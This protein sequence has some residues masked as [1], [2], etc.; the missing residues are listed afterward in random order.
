MP[1]QAV[2]TASATL[3]DMPL[4]SDGLG[5]VTPLATVTVK[6]Q[7]NGQLTQVAFQEGQ[8]VKRGDFLAQIDPRPYQITLQQAQGQLAK[9]QGLLSQA[10]ADL[11]R[12]QTLN[13]QDS[14]SRQQVDDQQYLVQQDQ[15][16]VTADQASVNNAELNL[17]YCHIVSPVDG[18]VG[19]R[20]V[21]QGNYVQTSDTTGLV[22][23]TQLQPITVIFTLPEDSIPQ[24]LARLKTGA[25]LPVMA[26]DRSNTTQIATGTLETVD[27][28]IDTTTGTV[29]LRATFP[30][31][32]DA[33]FPNQFVN[34]RLLVDT[35]HNAVI[36]PTPAIQ[37][38][39]PGTYVYVV[40]ADD[41]VS[42][43]PIVIGPTDGE[44]TTVTSGLKP[45]ENVVIDGADRLR[46]GAKVAVNNAP[47][48]PS[49][50]APPA[51]HRRGQGGHRHRP[52][53]QSD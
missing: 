31:T 26:F 38:G 2:R 14:I 9:D 30:N 45:G 4:I 25:T 20:L 46:E 50:N 42:V 17:V 6:T 51:G 35:L 15:G 19:L 29:K 39:A 36:V 24:V 11:V 43:R 23:I 7:I 48:A 5:T 37:R 53:Q 47:T 12:Y 16:T 33:L 13:R 49:A 21:D 8:L 41:T 10:R 28:E 34:A 27:N 52:P 32:D 40:G 18:R 1:P 22:V 44:R 3:G